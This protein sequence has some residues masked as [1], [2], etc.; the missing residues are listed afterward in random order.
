[1]GSTA[2]RARSGK[3]LIRWSEMGLIQ[4][5]KFFRKH[6][7]GTTRIDPTAWRAEMLWS[8]EPPTFLIRN[9][10]DPP[11]WVPLAL[12]WLSPSWFGSFFY[13]IFSQVDFNDRGSADP[14]S[15]IPQIYHVS[16]PRSWPF[17]VETVTIRKPYYGSVVCTNTLLIVG[18]SDGFT[19]FLRCCLLTL[20]SSKAH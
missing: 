13:Q 3:A 11:R 4:V 16:E 12:P 5:S 7:G 1:M 14:K 2:W 6:R 17:L 15:T 18:L 10:I 19:V 9:G 8:D 20:Y